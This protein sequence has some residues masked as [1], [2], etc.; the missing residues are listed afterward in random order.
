MTDSLL[1][2]RH[3]PLLLQDVDARIARAFASPALEPATR[4]VLR[5]LSENH[6][7]ARNTIRARELAA[8]MGL[9]WGEGARRKITVAVAT[10][11]HAPYRI[12]IGASRETPA[13]YFL[14]VTAQELAGFNKVYR[15]QV[16]T[17]IELLY[18]MNGLEYAQAFLLK[19]N[20]ELV[21]MDL[22]AT[23]AKRAYDAVLA[24]FLGRG[25]PA[26][27][28]DS[29]EGGSAKPSPLGPSPCDS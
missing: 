9:A 26:C 18:E 2:T 11:R 24:N 10:L 17:S 22:K 29:D 5:V 25:G 15:E 12:P 20:G 21:G 27:P 23:S 3:S 13:G 6:R 16:A 7:G 8:A 28:P 1:A 14:I 19:L 4:Q